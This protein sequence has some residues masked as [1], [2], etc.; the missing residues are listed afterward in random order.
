[1]PR[2]GWLIAAGCAVFVIGLPVGFL[3]LLA[4]AV[5]QA[6]C[7]TSGSPTGPGPASVTGIPENLLPVFEGAAQQSQLGSDGWAYLAG[8]NYAESTFDTDTGPGSGVTSGS[9]YAGAAGP[10]QIGIGG[11]ATDNWDT[12]VGEI[13]P[14]LP[15]GTQPPSVYNEVDAVYAAAALLKQWGA[16]GSW[17][18]ALVAWNDYPPEIEEVTQLVAQYT[19][20]DQG[21]GGAPEAT[22][23]AGAG[24]AT[25]PVGGCL[26]ISG[27]TT[28]G[29][30]AQIL[31]DGTAAIPTG[32]P[33]QVQEAI[34]A[35][36]RIIDTF[37]SQERRANMLTQVQ[38]SYDCS[39]AT[40]FVL[41]NA[42]LGNTPQVDVG[43]GVAGDGGMLETYGQ[44]GQGQWISVYGSS[45]H[46]FV[47][48]AGI[49]LDTAHYAPVQ[50]AS[51]PDS[52]PADDPD[53]GGPTSGPRWQPASIIP[54]QLHD[55]NA[56][57]VS[58][59]P[60]L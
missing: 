28:P 22:G 47:E 58:H 29:A 21:Q 53:N 6:S 42:G 59:P 40:D 18:A 50:P 27:V 34:A 3:L 54:S 48:V 4:P 46:A 17:Q 51:V 20:D 31:P 16:P 45:G 12:V 25:E 32:A 49:V 44:P 11:A 38:D 56:W 14:N 37:Y 13:P 60:G 7:G 36:N 55:G 15:G 23:T 52:Y 57:S 43:N 5:S 33:L 8:L 1:M 10:M 26:P 39:G 35:G 19:H 2:I 30:V 41:F 24:A 9:N